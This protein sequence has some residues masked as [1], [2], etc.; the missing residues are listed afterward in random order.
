MEGARHCR[1]EASG[2]ITLTSNPVF[3]ITSVI[4]IKALLNGDKIFSG[5]SSLEFMATV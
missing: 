5:I 4:C 1:Y 3:V 2:S